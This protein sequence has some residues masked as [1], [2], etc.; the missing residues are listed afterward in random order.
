MEIT[1]EMWDM[2]IGRIDKMDKKIDKLNALRIWKAKVTGALAV[3]SVVLIP[4][5][6]TIVKLW[7]E[8]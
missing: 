1:E 2:L 4:V 7:L 5:A 3:I 6:I 8:K